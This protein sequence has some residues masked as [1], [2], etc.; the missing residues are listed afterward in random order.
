MNKSSQSQPRPSLSPIQIAWLINHVP[1]F[2]NMY[3]I[4]LKMHNVP[5]KQESTKTVK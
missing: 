5:S 2:Q 4:A 1:N 3:S